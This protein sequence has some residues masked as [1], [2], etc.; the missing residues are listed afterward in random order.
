MISSLLVDIETG[1]TSTLISK[2]QTPVNNDFNAYRR[3]AVEG[4]LM[5]FVGWL[6][7]VCLGGQ[8]HELKT[9]SPGPIKQLKRQH[10]LVKRHRNKRP[11]QDF[12]YLRR[13]II[14]K[15]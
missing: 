2:I 4:S 7:G 5:V 13:P 14:M 9:F 10:R 1:L 12:L 3:L 8:E 6:R 15:I 11:S